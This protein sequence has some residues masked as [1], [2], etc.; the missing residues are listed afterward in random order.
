MR[1]KLV[2]ICDWLPPDFGAVGQYSLMFARAHAAEGLDVLLAGLSSQSNSLAEESVCAGRLRIFR[3]RAKS[4]DKSDFLRRSWWTLKVNLRLVWKVWPYLRLAD[5]IKFTG[6]PPF[7]LHVLAPLNAWLLRKKLT[8]RITDFHPE[9]LM[10]TM[11][12]VPLPL[13]WFYK[14]TLY[15]RRRVDQFEVLGGDQQHLLQRMGIPEERVLLKRDP[16]PVIISADTNPLERPTELG[17]R[18][19]LLYSGNYGVA[20]DYQTFIAA[21]RLHHEQGSGRVGFW[22]NAVGSKADEVEQALRQLKLPVHRSQPVA[23][24][25]LS[26]LLVTPDAHLITLLDP[27]VGLVMPSKVYGCIE[28][29]R[30]VVYVGSRESDVHLLCS[31]RVASGDYWQL[32]VGDVQGLAGALE[33]LADGP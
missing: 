33:A 8:Y 29:R 6:S 17:T 20:H 27:F 23:L 21:Y 9:S 28:S 1:R 19:L 4:Y 2:Y 10:A 25:E 3:L 11:R 26:R 13:R 16:S 22:L 30:P 31:E 15:W 12:R 14:L 5:E 32:S 7:M 24:E 18:F